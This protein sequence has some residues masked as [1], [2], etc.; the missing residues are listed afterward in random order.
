MHRS[1]IESEAADDPFEP[2]VLLRPGAWRISARRLAAAPALFGRGGLG[3]S[4][5]LRVTR[6]FVESFQKLARA[7]PTGLS[8]M[9]ASAPI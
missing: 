3:L 4:R 9:T 7:L 5:L 2:D 6:G 8:T 1:F